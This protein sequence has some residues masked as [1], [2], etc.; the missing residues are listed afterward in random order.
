MPVT[1]LEAKELSDNVLTPWVI[2]EFVT[3]PFLEYLPFDNTV[4]AAGMGQS[5]SYSYGRVIEYAT[6]Q[7]RA[8]NTEYAPQE[9]KVKRVTVDLKQFGG[10]FEIDRVLQNNE[11]EVIAS[12]FEWQAQQK[13]KSTRALFSDMVINGNAEADPT[14]FTGIDKIVTGT[15]TEYIPDSAVDIST[16]TAIATN[17]K[18]FMF[19]LRQSL[20]PLNAPPTFMLVNRD[21]FATFQSVADELTGFT[22]TKT[23]L[24]T[25][26]MNYAGIGILEMGNKPGTN[27]PII[28]T[29]SDGT[30]SAYFVR[31]GLD[32]VHAVS[33]AGTSPVDIFLPDWN[34]PLALKRGEVEMV[35]ALCV[36]DTRSIGAFRNIKVV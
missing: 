25:N 3:D 32:G 14:Q 23:A 16:A 12:M 13:I 27:D 26:I 22:M 6:A 19:D 33:P 5:L 35:G 8:L 24:G 9:A 17:A 2:D 31:L 29:A 1:L 4:K 36:K 20:K 30:T 15:S 34:S 7:T 28:E 10:A 11:R 18:Q 21:L